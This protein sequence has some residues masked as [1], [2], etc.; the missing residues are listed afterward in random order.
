MPGQVAAIALYTHFQHPPSAAVVSAVEEEV[1]SIAAPL[2]LDL[3]WK[4]L[5]GEHPA[6]LALQQLCEKDS[7]DPRVES[8]ARLLYDQAVIAE[9]SKIKDPVAFARVINELLVKGAG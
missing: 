8:Y 9:G 3:E 2:G 5:N 7:S 1:G 6:V 4:E